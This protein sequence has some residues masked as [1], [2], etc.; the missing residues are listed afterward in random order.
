MKERAT[1]WICPLCSS[2]N[3]VESGKCFVC[4]Y[5]LPKIPS[6]EDAAIFYEQALDLFEKGR[7]E[8]AAELLRAAAEAKHLPAILDLAARCKA[9][10]GVARDDVQAYKLYV[11]AAKKNSPEGQFE[12][13][14]CCLC[15]IGTKPDAE[16]ALKWLNKAIVKEYL[17]AMRLMMELYMTGAYGVPVNGRE[18]NEILNRM[19]QVLISRGQDAEYLYADHAEIYMNAHMYEQALNCLEF[20]AAARRGGPKVLY[21]LAKC[22]EKGLGCRFKHPFKAARLYKKARKQGFVFPEE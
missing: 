18:A 3:D 4:D 2:A 20:L 15:G 16:R 13:A 22:Y 1:V 19:R 21:L 12:L 14:Q 5:E 10:R 17:P 6:A 8:K 7:D 11:Q 9:G